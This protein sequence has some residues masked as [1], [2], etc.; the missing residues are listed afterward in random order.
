MVQRPFSQA[1]ENN[2]QP[3]LAILARYLIEPT[4]VLEIGSGTGQHGYF[5]AEQL[6]HI[7]WQ[8]SD[9]AENHEGILAWVDSYVG[10]NL[11][12]PFELNVAQFPS[13][14]TAIGA[15]YTANTA[16]IMSW[17]QAIQMIR[18]VGSLLPSGGLWIIYGPFNYEGQ[19]TSES[20]ANFNDW[21][22]AQATH[23]AIRDFEA[24]CEEA[25]AVGLSLLEDCSMPANNRCLV[26]QK[27]VG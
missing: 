20:N 9:L 22:K 17:D 10:D 19:F 3:I 18:G 14:L 11:L 27:T 7:T 23:R 4:Q 15:V 2:K 26:F 5:F 24:V 21:L 6:P 13:D 12:P 8:T 25:K 16:H 1:C